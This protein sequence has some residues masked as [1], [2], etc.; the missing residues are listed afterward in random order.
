MIGESFRIEK[1]GGKRGKGFRE[2]TAETAKAR[3][4]PLR[5]GNPARAVAGRSGG[6]GWLWFGLGAD[7][8]K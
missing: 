1:D 4:N 3:T 7:S 6:R 8:G 5:A 2:K